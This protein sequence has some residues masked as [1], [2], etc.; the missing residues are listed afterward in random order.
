MRDDDPQKPPSETKKQDWL[1]S[2]VNVWVNRLRMANDRSV[3]RGAAEKLTY[4]QEAE[5][6]MGSILPLPKHPLGPGYVLVAREGTY[7]ALGRALRALFA[8]VTFIKPSKAAHRSPSSLRPFIKAMRK[9]E[10]Q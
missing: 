3:M 2:E 9:G 1:K 8:L 6:A 5:T 7:D 10:P 4:R